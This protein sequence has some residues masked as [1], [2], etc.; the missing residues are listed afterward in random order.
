MTRHLAAELIE[1]ILS[2]IHDTQTLQACS[3]AAR[4]FRGPAQRRLWKHLRVDNGT[5]SYDRSANVVVAHLD[6]SPHLAG[7]VCSLDLF[8]IRALEDDFD[9]FVEKILKQLPHVKSA[10]ISTTHR[11]RHSSPWTGSLLQTAIVAFIQDGVARGTLRQLELRGFQRVPRSFITPFLRAIPTLS[12]PW[13]TLEKEQETLPVVVPSQDTH[14]LKMGI[15]DISNPAMY[16][17]ILPHTKILRVLVLDT[18]GFD[19]EDWSPDFEPIRSR[20][21][22]FCVAVGATLEYLSIE[23]PVDEQRFA[24]ADL[25]VAPLP[26]LR[27]L[28]IDFEN[29]SDG[30]ALDP[31]SDVLDIMSV[32]LANAPLLSRVCLRADMSIEYG[33]LNHW[34]GQPEY[35]DDFANMTDTLLETFLSAPSRTSC[36]VPRFYTSRIRKMP[37]N[38]TVKYTLPVE[39]PVH[40][41]MLATYAAAMRVALP[42][43]T[44]LGFQV[45]DY[46]L[47]EEWK[48]KEVEFF[49]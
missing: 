3:V 14:R 11:N 22:D 1:H 30:P 28:Q 25:R 7:Y 44:A 10:S 27:F 36:C 35:F 47:G 23:I 37:T 42:K 9:E 41:G 16:K 29:P 5:T 38:R 40:S 2:F 12:L 17:F 19:T 24:I 8:L 34:L 15:F 4:M 21:Y 18:S 45:I 33:S 6:E 20:V 39:D 48:E 26:Q 13:L 49:H 43:A 46:H 31:P 32:L